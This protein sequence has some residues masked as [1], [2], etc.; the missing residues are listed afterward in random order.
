MQYCNMPS[1]DGERDRQRVSTGGR[2]DH[3]GDRSDTPT[4]SA[5]QH[6]QR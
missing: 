6:L 3:P 2:R 4:G 5:L 1:D